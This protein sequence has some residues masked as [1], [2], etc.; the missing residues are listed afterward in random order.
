M[1]LQVSLPTKQPTSNGSF[2]EGYGSIQTG[3][4]VL[5]VALATLN[6]SPCAVT[7][8]HCVCRL[9]D[10]ELPSY[11]GTTRNHYKDPYEPASRMME[12]NKGFEHH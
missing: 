10:G 4:L 9:G 8:S 12:V 6:R 7:S 3:H 1:P 5:G 2:F 11:M